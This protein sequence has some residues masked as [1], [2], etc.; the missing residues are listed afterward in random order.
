MFTKKS[1][2]ALIK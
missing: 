1:K 2:E